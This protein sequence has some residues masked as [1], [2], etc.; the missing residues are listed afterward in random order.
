MGLPP[1][2]SSDVVIPLSWIEDSNK[3]WAE[4]MEKGIDF[5]SP[6]FDFKIGVDVAGMGNDLTVFAPRYTS[7][8][9]DMFAP[10][11]THGKID[12]IDIAYMIRDKFRQKTGTA[13]IDTIGEGAGTHQRLKEFDEAG[14]LNGVTVS[15]KFSETADGTDVTGEREFYNKRA[16]L[17]WQ[18]RDALDPQFDP[19][20]ALPPDPELM[21]ELAEIRKAKKTTE[22]RENIIGEE[23]RA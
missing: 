3:R 6:E 14:D 1:L 9:I 5:D 19:K 22:Q 15:T 17:Y 8:E 21:Q 12:N 18:I 2:E 4:I 23:R 10:L 13:F 7:D 16:H 11:E 20:L